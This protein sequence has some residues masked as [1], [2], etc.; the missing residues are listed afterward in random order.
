MARP[1][2][3]YQNLWPWCLTYLLKTLTLAITFRWY[4]LW[5]WYFTWVLL[6]WVPNFFDLDVKNFNFGCNFQMVCTR[7]LIFHISV[8][9][10]K[11]FPWAPNIF[12]LLT[13]MFDPLIK[14]FNLGCNFQMVCTTMLTFHMSVSFDKIFSCVPKFLTLWPWPSCLTLWLKSLT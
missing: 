11:T 13:L 2:H 6:S 3:G 12:E 14:N 8:S 1:F 10:S 9:Y 4:V 5:C 7:A